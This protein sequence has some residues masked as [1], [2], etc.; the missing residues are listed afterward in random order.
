MLA[1][2]LL[3]P[4]IGA[5]VLVTEALELGTWASTAGAM[6]VGLLLTLVDRPGFYGVEPRPKDRSRGAS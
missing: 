3:I 1:Y 4:A 2:L 6:I 5:V